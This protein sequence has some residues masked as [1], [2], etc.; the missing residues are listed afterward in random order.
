MIALVPDPHRLSSDT[1]SLSMGAGG[2]LDGC[3]EGGFRWPVGQG[4]RQGMRRTPPPPDLAA[5][6][7]PPFWDLSG[8]DLAAWVAATA[9]NFEL[10]RRH[11][12]E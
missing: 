4:R 2:P 3:W 10:R 5:L 7:P 1:L 9:K 8:V 12:V 11:C 6:R